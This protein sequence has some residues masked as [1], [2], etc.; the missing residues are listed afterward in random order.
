MKR[1]SLCLTIALAAMTVQLIAQNH[2]HWKC[3]VSSAD[4]QQIKQAMMDTRQEMRDFV[5]PRSVVTYV[6]VRFYLVAKNNGD[7]R[8]SEVPALQAI[9]HMNENYQDLEI[10]FYIK[11]FKYVN[12]TSIRNDPQNF[13]GIS[14]I[15][16]EMIYDAINVFVVPDA[17]DGA[18]AYYQLPYGPNGNDW[19]VSSTNYLDDVTTLT[20]EVG[21]FF[22][23]NHPFYGWEPSTAGGW[24]EA[25]HGNPVTQFYA[26]D[27]VTPVEKVDGSNCQTAGD[28]IC[29]TPADYMFPFPNGC[30]LN[31]EVKDVN[32]DVLE[33][34]FHNFMNYASCSNYYFSED[35][36]EVINNS[37]F[38]S[39]RNYV[40][41]NI[42]PNLAEVTEA[43]TIIS[44]AENET[45]TTY[46]SVSIEWTA[47]PNAEQYFVEIINLGNSTTRYIVQT[48]SMVA[49]DLAPDGL[50]LM[51]VKAFTP[52]STCAPLSSARKFR[53]GNDA[54]DTSE[55]LE[56]DE[57]SVTPN[58]LKRGENL[59][60]NIE[61][62]IGIE[63][64]LKVFNITGQLMADYPGQQFPSGVSSFEI[65]TGNFAQGIYFVT[66]QTAEG[67]ESRRVSIVD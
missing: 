23:L 62:G 11:E 60:V 66:L 54:V 64:D 19:I 29:D 9:C 36:K 48:N 3:G 17:G 21:H 7:D 40:R 52:Y 58:P 65:M 49:T 59:L 4:G 42:T 26:P 5:R 41:P 2:D 50:F 61:S 46:N 56:L 51:K 53:T 16:G 45:I 13:G 38:S 14:A 25:L 57:W 27:G 8:P 28:G 20:H 35:Q 63:A 18:A 39:A 10:Q 67:M 32:G 24:S 15:S 1:I 55:L 31:I 33:P 22:S 37:L 6:P 44:P 47:V 12:N 43:P 30:N 34:D